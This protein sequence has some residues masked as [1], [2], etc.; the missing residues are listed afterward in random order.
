MKQLDKRK[1]WFAALQSNLE[2][3]HALSCLL[4]NNLRGGE[5]LFEIAKPM[6]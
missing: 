6:R 3:K 1:K 5:M 4:K 2:F